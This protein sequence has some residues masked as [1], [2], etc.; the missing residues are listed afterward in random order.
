M[1]F[2]LGDRQTHENWNRCKEHL[3]PKTLFGNGPDVFKAERKPRDESG[4]G[5]PRLP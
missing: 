2:G 3:V 1:K 5:A 4:F